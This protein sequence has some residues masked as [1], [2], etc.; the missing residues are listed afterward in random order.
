VVKNGHDYKGS[1]KYH[2]KT[3]KRY[4]TLHAQRGYNQHIRSQVKRTLLEEVSLR[5]V[6]SNGFLVFHGTRWPSGWPNGR[7]QAALHLSGERI[8]NTG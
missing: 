7:P 5:S 2:C 3:C 8:C 1:Q 4:G 6:A